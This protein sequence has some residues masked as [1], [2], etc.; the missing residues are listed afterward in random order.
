VRIA[1]ERWLTPD[2]ELIFGQGVKPTVELAMPDTGRALGPQEVA[3]LAPAAVPTME[4][5]QLLKAIQLL[6]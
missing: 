5:A 1:V 4:D 2:G 3:T 6:Q